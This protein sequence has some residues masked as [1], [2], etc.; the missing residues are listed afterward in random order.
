MKSYGEHLSE[1]RSFEGLPFIGE[2]AY[3]LFLTCCAYTFHSSLMKMILKVIDRVGPSPY[4][5]K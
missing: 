3:V 1:N 4:T 5:R 2:E